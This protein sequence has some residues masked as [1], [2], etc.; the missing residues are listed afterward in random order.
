MCF[1]SQLFFA[2]SFLNGMNLDILVMSVIDLFEW[3]TLKAHTYALINISNV[4]SKW[5][6]THTFTPFKA[7]I[8]RSSFLSHQL[9]Q[10]VATGERTH[11]D[12][13]PIDRPTDTHTRE[14][15]AREIH[16]RELTT[17][18]Q[19]K[20][21]LVSNTI[22]HKMIYH[23]RIKR[24]ATLLFWLWIFFMFCDAKMVFFIHSFLFRLQFYTH[25]T[26]PVRITNIIIWKA[27]NLRI[28]TAT[29]IHCHIYRTRII[30][31]Y[32]K[33]AA[34]EDTSEK[35]PNPF[36]L[37]TQ[38]SN[39]QTLFYLERFITKRDQSAAKQNQQ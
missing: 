37:Y 19:N 16:S 9:S 12:Q 31:T 33:Q 23:F 8:L 2:H 20:R 30:K 6:I 7:R 26:H 29:R 18:G 15:R 3:W 10:R 27:K 38:T 35:E 13:R 36:V 32:L 4:L 21:T 17:S 5:Q 25:Q 28:S 22:H 39:K 34:I 14:R 1:Q 11:T 24:L